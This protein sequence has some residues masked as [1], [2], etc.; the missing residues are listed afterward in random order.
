MNAKHA[1]EFAETPRTTTM[2]LDAP[3]TG[4]L[5]PQVANKPGH[6]ARMLGSSKCDS[7]NCLTCNPRVAMPERLPA[8]A[9]HVHYNAHANYCHHCLDSNAEE[10]EQAEGSIYCAAC[11]ATSREQAAAQAPDHGLLQLDVEQLRDA[12]W[13]EDPHNAASYD[14][15]L[16]ELR[17]ALANWLR[18]HKDIQTALVVLETPNGSLDHSRMRTLYSAQDAI[19]QRLSP[20]AREQ[21]ADIGE[22]HLGDGMLVRWSEHPH[23][24]AGGILVARQVFDLSLL[25]NAS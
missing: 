5:C 24:D 14:S 22:L 12:V 11:L 17:E 20:E 19:L 16:A 15:T 21:L 3:R 10:V 23:L 8:S 1:S 6:V 4:E 25:H 18:Q 9:R 2:Q 7:R 13:E